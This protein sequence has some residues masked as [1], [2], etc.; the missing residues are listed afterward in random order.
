VGIAS[1]R[2][3]R[4]LNFGYEN[5]LTNSPIQQLVEDGAG[6]LWLVTGRE[7]FYQYRS[8]TEPPDTRITAATKSVPHRGI[9]VFS[10]QAS[11]AWQRTPA[12][13]LLY[14]WRVLD[15]NGAGEIVP[16]NN[17]GSETAYIADTLPPGTY[18]FEVRASDDA[19]NVDPTPAAVTFTVLGPLWR[20][21]RVMVPAMLL[22]ALLAIALVLRMRGHRALRQSKAALVQSNQQ[23]M[24]EIKERLLAEQRL[25]DHFEQLEEL[26]RGRTSE[27]ETAQRALVEQERL[28]TLGKVT[29]SVSHELRNPLGTLRSTL[30]MIGRKVQGTDLGL[31]DALARGER[32]IQRCDRIIEEFLDFT[33]SVA[34]EHE[35]VAMDEWLSELMDE[36]V[37]PEDIHREYAFESDVKLDVDPERLRRAV[38]NVVNNAVQAMNEH[39]GENKRLRVASRIRGD[40]FEIVVSDNGP[41]MSEENIPRIFE[42]LYSTKGFGVGLGVPIVRDIMVKHNGGVDYESALGMGTTVV[43]W[44][45]RERTEHGSAT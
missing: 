16:W 18:M 33:R 36:I 35:V 28:A 6:S 9:G 14:S 24:S 40:R 4:W 8:D 17:F 15:E 41:G 25:N 43:L 32:S 3:E 38:V 42:P 10:F 39:G 19:R 22:V 37:V 31:E 27:L 2:E 12:H 5:G 29:A 44:I 45:P 11:D 7:G 1:Y 21:P 34:M 23:L 30:F 20:E 26:I 13:A